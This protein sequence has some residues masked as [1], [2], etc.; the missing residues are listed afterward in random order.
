[1]DYTVNYTVN[2]PLRDV[3]ADVKEPGTGVAADASS[4]VSLLFREPGA[5]RRGEVGAEKGKGKEFVFCTKV[6]SQ[7]VLSY[8]ELDN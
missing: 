4:M 6:F 5:S 3:A 1:M 2:H 8:T 7:V